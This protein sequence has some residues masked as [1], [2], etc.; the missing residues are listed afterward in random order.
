[1]TGDNSLSPAY[2]GVCR[3][4]IVLADFTDVGLYGE[5]GQAPGSVLV[6]ATKELL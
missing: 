6:R 1:M 5:D 3:H 2:L 4:S